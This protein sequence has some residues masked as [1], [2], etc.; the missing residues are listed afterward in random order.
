MNQDRRAKHRA[1]VARA[2]ARE[3][4]GM[5]V[6]RVEI[7]ME[8]LALFLSQA[9]GHAFDAD[10]RIALAIGTRELLLRLMADVTHH[11]QGP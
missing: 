6:V 7:H 5:G 9:L 2:R 11:G 8:D 10:D 3:A 1:H 4:K